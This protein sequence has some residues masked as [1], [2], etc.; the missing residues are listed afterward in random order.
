MSAF[1]ECDANLAQS[2][3]SGDPWGYCTQ[4]HCDDNAN[5]NHQF[6]FCQGQFNKPRYKDPQGNCLYTGGSLIPIAVPGCYC[7]CSCFAFDTPIAVTATTTRAVQEFEIDDPVLVAEKPDLKSWVQKPVLFSSGTGPNGKNRLIRIRFGNRTEGIK[8]TQK[9]FVSQFV[10][11]K[12]SADYFKLLSSPPNDVIGKD[13]LVNLQAVRNISAAGISTLLGCPLTVAQAIMDLLKADSDYLLVNGDQPFLMKDRT[14]KLAKYLRPGVDQLLTADGSTTPIRSMEV[15]MFAKGIHHIATSRAPAKSMD[16]HLLLANGI[17][18]GD[19]AIQRGISGGQAAGIEDVHQEQPV[20]GTREYAKANAH[21]VTTPFAA[22]ATAPGPEQ[23]GGNFESGHP[24]KSSFIP[25]H[26]LSF[27]T[28]AQAEELL[29]TAPIYPASKNAAEPDVRYLFQLFGAF[30]PDITFYYDQHAVLPNVYGFEQ[31][32]RSF[33][34]VTLGWTL[35][36]GL[37]FQGIAMA[38]A[39]AVNALTQKTPSDGTSPVA[40]ADFNIYPVFLSLFYRA[41]DAVKHYNLGLRQVKTVFGYI[42]DNPTG[43]DIDLDCRIRTLGNS[44]NALPLPNCAGGPPDPALELVSVTAAQ[45][46]KGKSPVV[47]ISF[48]L[49][50]DET[51]ATA[52]GN[53]LFDPDVVVY[54]ATIDSGDKKKVNLSAEIE[55]DTPY[56][57]VATG[58]LSADQQPLVPGKNGGKFTLSSK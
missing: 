18:V 15:G 44:I 17:V 52:A 19:Y 40:V 57:M 28:R 45:G 37:Y 7:C 25:P 41:P 31:Y 35:L 9:S 1:P 49:D 47:S 55:T 5:Y 26:A 24:D 33:V 53:Y 48:N 23:A 30:F 16:G 56:N 46:P 2:Q 43:D 12:Q 39:H 6:C 20:F 58:V 54:S 22:Y 13:G 36:E 29:N 38:I 10:T 50:V 27:I 8:V 3:A 11:T 4:M 51:T 32:G 21:L 42:K 14:L 34:V